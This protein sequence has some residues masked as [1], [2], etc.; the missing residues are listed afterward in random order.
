M[1]STAGV[2]ELR[3]KLAGLSG[4][5]ASMLIVRQLMLAMMADV[6]WSVLA[7]GRVVAKVRLAVEALLCAGKLEVRSQL[8]RHVV[9]CRAPPSCLG[10]GGCQRRREP[11]A[12]PPTVA[13]TRVAPRHA[14]IFRYLYPDFLGFIDVAVATSDGVTGT[15]ATAP[16]RWM[17]QSQLEVSMMGLNI[18]VM[19][20]IAISLYPIVSRDTYPRP[21]HCLSKIKL[22]WQ[23]VHLCVS[24]DGR[25]RNAKAP[26]ARP[27]SSVQSSSPSYRTKTV[28]VYECQ[29]GRQRRSTV[30]MCP[31][32][33][34]K[35]MPFW[36]LCLGGPNLVYSERR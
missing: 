28:R 2:R 9:G 12:E 8:G 33:E 30:Y 18:M 10:V 21:R 34:R 23:A 13:Q 15:T 20:Y 35:E 4:S 11:L 5:R 24:K 32:R 17:R 29:R 7:Q 16:A 36:Y 14:K 31:K 6:Q 1:G 26:I 19:L 22:P 3:S 27:E 25:P